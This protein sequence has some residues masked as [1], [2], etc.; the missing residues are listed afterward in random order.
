MSSGS[1]HLHRRP[2]AG[3]ASTDC[4]TA[5]CARP[6]DSAPAGASGTLQELGVAPVPTF[7]PFDVR[8]GVPV[9]DSVWPK[10]ILGAMRRAV[11]DQ[12]AA[13]G[14]DLRA[15]ARRIFLSR[16]GFTQRQL[17][18]EAEIINALARY[19]FEVVYPEKLSFIEQIA[20][21]HSADVIVGSASSAMT[22]TIFCNDK[23]R[24]VALIH[25]NRSFNFRGY[26]SMIGSSDAKVLFIRGSTV[27]G[28]KNASV[29]RQLHGHARRGAAR[30]GT[31]RAQPVAAGGGT[32]CGRRR[33]SSTSSVRST[34]ATPRVS[35]RRWPRCS[36]LSLHRDRARPRPC[37]TSKPSASGSRAAPVR[38]R[39]AG[40][41]TRRRDRPARS[42]ALAP[43]CQRGA[44]ARLH[45]S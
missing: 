8:P 2:H 34:A 35:W 27:P 37:G 24:V 12:L 7:F 15:T 19:G 28:E 22:N 6:A 32:A 3:N 42:P 9:Y 17:V 45:R 30:P 20:L 10:D 4:G 41:R 26:A 40:L 14:I 36:R 21:Y 16:K 31:R 39:G 18:N 25:E 43:D 23:A 1:P 5:R 33:S 11:L 44:P 38:R 13:R 29:P